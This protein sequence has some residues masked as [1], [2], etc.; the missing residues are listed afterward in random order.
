[1]KEIS[2]RE[3]VNGDVLYYKLST[4]TRVEISHNHEIWVHM[5]MRSKVIVR[6]SRISAVQCSGV[7]SRA[8]TLKA[9]FRLCKG[10]IFYD[11]TSGYFGN[12]LQ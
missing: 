7:L 6:Q 4:A 3:L 10:C 8:R 1:V 5:C 11:C 12:S 9:G 2:C